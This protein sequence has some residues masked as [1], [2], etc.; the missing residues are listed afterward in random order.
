[1]TETLNKTLVPP[2]KRTVN[3]LYKGLTLFYPES[4]FGTTKGKKSAVLNYWAEAGYKRTEFAELLW[5]I[6]KTEDTDQAAKI[7]LGWKK[8]W[9][10]NI[11][12]ETTVPEN[13][14]EILSSCLL[15]TSPSPRDRS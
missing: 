1:M 10:E 7:I 4:V 11:K 15:Y 14:D 8:L 6:T 3:F 9:D 2:S 12:P 5:N 13:L